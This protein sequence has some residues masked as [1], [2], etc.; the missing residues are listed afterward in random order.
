MTWRV[1]L[2]VFL[3]ACK[4]GSD[5]DA[6]PVDAQV[7]A[8][9]MADGGDIDGSIPSSGDGP[10]TLSPEACQTDLEVIREEDFEV[11][12]HPL[13][14][15]LEFYG[16]REGGLT[17]LRSNTVIAAA[18]Q[19]VDGFDDLTLTFNRTEIAVAPDHGDQNEP[20]FPVV[21]SAFMQGNGGLTNIR[22]LL[23]ADGA[24]D[25]RK[26]IALGDAVTLNGTTGTVRSFS[27]V[28]V[29]PEGAAMFVLDVDE[30][31]NSFLVRVDAPGAA[32]TVVLEEGAVVD[33]GLTLGEIDFF[34]ITTFG[35]PVVRAQIRR[36]ADVEGFAYLNVLWFGD[37]QCLTTNTSLS[38]PLPIAD[39]GPVAIDDFGSDGAVTGVVIRTNPSEPRLEYLLPSGPGEIERGV[40][41]QGIT[42]NNFKHPRACGRDNSLYFV[43]SVVDER[44]QVHD[45][46]FSLRIGGELAQLTDF[47]S[48]QALVSEVPDEILALALGYGCDAIMRT[49][50][51][52]REG[53]TVPYEG[54]WASFY[55]DDTME[56]IDE[57]PGRAEN[58]N[59]E[60][61]NITRS[62]SGVDP[63]ADAR[64]P[65]NI[66]PDGSLTFLIQ[67]I[68]A[69]GMYVRASQ[70]ADRCRA[71][72]IV[73]SD[74]DASDTAPG[75]GRCD[76]GQMSGSEPECTLR[77]ALE[78][79][80]AAGGSDTIEFDSTRTIT[81]ESPLPAI[82][83]PLVLE[84]S[85]STINGSGLSGDEAGLTVQVTGAFV[86][87][88]R[89]E[90]F[91]GDG[92][93]AQT[94]V[95]LE[96]VTLE[97]NCGWGL[98]LEAGAVLNDSQ[99]A[100][101]GAGDDCT[102]GGVLA[103][104]ENA[105]LRI[106]DTTISTNDGPGVLSKARVVIAQSE[107]SDNV[108]DGI[109]VDRAVFGTDLWVSHGT[110]TVRT[111]RGHGIVVQG[112]FASQNARVVIEDNCGWGVRMEDQA[113]T[114]EEPL[115]RGPQ[116]RIVNNGLTAVGGEG[117]VFWRFDETP[118]RTTG[119]CGGG[120][121]GAIGQDDEVRN[122]LFAI[123]I[124]DNQGPGVASSGTWQISDALFDGNSG[125]GVLFQADGD[126]TS[127]VVVRLERG[128][129]TGNLGAGIDVGSGS[130]QVR[131]DALFDTN[132]GAGI[133]S[134][135]GNIDL[136]NDPAR[137]GV[138]T[139]RRNGQPMR[140][141][142][143]WTLGDDWVRSSAPCEV[144]GGVVASE[145]NIDA[146]NPIIRD[147]IGPGVSASDP[148]SDGVGIVTIEGGEICGNSEADVAE[149]FNLTGVDTTC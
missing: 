148:D 52:T 131:G 35:S 132:V 106:S 27:Q 75:D 51:E 124:T 46:L 73:N 10:A 62:R 56:I 15:N 25:V 59:G 123:E 87:E 115:P 5:P 71:P 38:C 81:V 90:G 134:G 130:V 18:N 20:A 3:G 29:T 114:L 113:I 60:V 63:N 36:G 8:G 76:T 88:L 85:G 97:S 13:E 24:G 140:E 14:Y 74:G 67:R 120:G 111:N 22:C 79:A 12:D 57:T 34:T 95:T 143:I 19:T 54:Y 47:T 100:N 103:S 72:N 122:R 61:Q 50:G 6:G 11:L 66:A 93:R 77:A 9:P 118:E 139:V 107:V 55:G 104:N 94:D 137:P 127:A 64:T 40:E 89:I 129:F 45:E 110:L 98:N 70:P 105:S 17:A 28:Q 37:V 39:D 146:R 21:F 138:V 86:R 84:A 99:L 119:R 109:V 141:C 1:A 142:E 30:T 41:T 101:N 16:L 26:I 102:A 4:T 116:H 92:V 7:D 33:D 69:G 48:L 65:S 23:A 149:T 91:P 133:V 31:S 42:F 32:P 2:L 96:G 135:A 44:G 136:N 126:E 82:S 43:G 112:E 68:D 147:N 58:G 53:S 145:G 80:N 78:E 144:Q 49:R 108:G 125:A 83:S 121:I 117:S 128:T